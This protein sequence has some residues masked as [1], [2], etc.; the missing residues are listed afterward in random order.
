MEQRGDDGAR[1]SDAPAER[2]G[3]RDFLQGAG[4]TATVAT[5]SSALAG[6]LVGWATARGRAAAAFPARG[7]RPFISPGLAWA[8]QD[9]PQ[10]CDGPQGFQ[11]IQGPEGCGPQGGLMGPQG[12]LQG[13][14]GSRGPQGAEGPQG[15]QGA[16]GPQGWWG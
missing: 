5:V 14:Q 3:R 9:G 2:I 12:G 16:P 13:P 7:R 4:R 1:A 11:G 6:G 15:F 8:V 10:G